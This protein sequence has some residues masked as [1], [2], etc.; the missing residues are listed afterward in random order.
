MESLR[1]IYD[2]V[3]I[4]KEIEEASEILLKNEAEFDTSPNMRAYNQLSDFVMK[5]I[6]QKSEEYNE[7]LEKFL[8]MVELIEEANLERIRIQSAQ[9]FKENL[10]LF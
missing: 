4:P 10:G 2:G 7:L 6:P 5:I 1:K 3:K 8:K 9:Y